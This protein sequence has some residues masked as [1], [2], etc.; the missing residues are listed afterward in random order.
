VVADIHFLRPG[1]IAGKFSTAGAC[2]S[3][4]GAAHRHPGHAGAP[5]FVIRGDMNSDPALGTF[6]FPN[7]NL[8][9]PFG[10]QAAS[11]FFPVVISTSGQTTSTEPNSTNNILQFPPTREI[12]GRLTGTVFN[13]N[14]S[15]DGSNVTV[16]IS[17]GTDYSPVVIE[18]YVVIFRDAIVLPGLRIGFGAVIAAGA[19]VTKDVPAMTIVAG[20]PARP[21]RERTAV[22][23]NADLRRMSGY[24]GHSWRRPAAL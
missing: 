23:D 21:V 17:F 5:S 14:G 11:P 24:I 10:L 18:P 7:A 1:T 12:N 4:R 15:R 20:T 13:P 3:A 9:G 22:H 19:V 16:K 2:P 8:V 6:E